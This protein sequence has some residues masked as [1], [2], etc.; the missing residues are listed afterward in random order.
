LVNNQPTLH[1]DLKELFD[2]ATKAYKNGTLKASNKKQEYLYP[3][4]LMRVSKNIN[5]CNYT[6]VVTSLQSTYYKNDHDSNSWL[7]AKSYLLIKKL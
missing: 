1:I 5:G 3:A 4:K 2:Q 6:I 7:E